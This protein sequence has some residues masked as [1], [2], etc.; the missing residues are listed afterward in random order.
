MSCRSSAEVSRRIRRTIGR[1]QASS[2]RIEAKAKVQ[3]QKAIETALKLKEMCFS[4][5]QIVKATS[6]TIDEI[7]K[8]K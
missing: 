5:A 6:L 1:G 4:I 2:N 7:E 3:H 8:L